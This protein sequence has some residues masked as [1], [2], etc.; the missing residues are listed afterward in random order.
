M[1]TFRK[2]HVLYLITG[3][4]LGLNTPACKKIS[5]KKDEASLTIRMTDAPANY[6][7]INVEVIGMEIFHENE[8]WITIPCEQGIY[9]LLALQNNISVVLADQVKVPVGTLTQIRLILGERNTIETYTSVHE[10]KVPSGSES[11]LKIEVGQVITSRDHLVLLIDFD[12]SASVVETGNDK[13]ILK[14]VLKLK[15]AQKV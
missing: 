10:L 8:G 9:N 12:A 14:P 2:I 11:G 4:L 13:Y 6:S 3:I 1:K 7:K 15:S 5:L